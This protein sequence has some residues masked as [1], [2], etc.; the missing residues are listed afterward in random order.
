MKTDTSGGSQAVGTAQQRHGALK[1]EEQGCLLREVW[2]IKGETVGLE[3]AG[4]E[5]LVWHMEEVLFCL[6]A[7]QNLNSLTRD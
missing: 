7:S 6:L 1:Q 4:C 2:V 5:E 3:A